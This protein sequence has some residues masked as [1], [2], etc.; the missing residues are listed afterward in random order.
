MDHAEERLHAVSC[1]FGSIGHLAN[2]VCSMGRQDLVALA[3]KKDL[4]G[5]SIYSAQSISDIPFTQ[6]SH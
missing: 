5:L 2:E 1:A 3:S 4:S 6:D